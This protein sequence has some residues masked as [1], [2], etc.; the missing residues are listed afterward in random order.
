M[1]SA[2]RRE[3][4]SH[5]IMDELDVEVALEYDRILEAFSAGNMA[6]PDIG[7]SQG[8]FLLT[9]LAALGWAPDARVLAGAIPH[10]ADAFGSKEVRTTLIRLGYWSRPRRISGDELGVLR[11]AAIVSQSDDR[12]YLLTNSREGAQLGRIDLVGDW[13]FESISPRQ[14]YLVIEISDAPAWVTSG[15]SLGAEKARDVLRRFTPEFRYALLISVVSGCIAVAGALGITIIFDNVLPSGNMATLAWIVVGFAV[16]FIFEYLLKSLAGRAVSRTSARL[17][18]IFGTALFEK[19]L[20]LPYNLL[21]GAPIGAQLARLKQ[22]QAVR[23]LPSGS[24]AQAIFGLPLAF[25]SLVASQWVNP[26][27]LLAAE[28]GE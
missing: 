25:V 22:F 13:H 16:L 9:L 19:L 21:S 4:T 28:S 20:R 26:E 27:R 23:E 17:E 3:P 18:Y 2:A 6:G 8:A 24:L 7:L 1:K 12:M 15:G 5:P 11:S 10:Y 14:T